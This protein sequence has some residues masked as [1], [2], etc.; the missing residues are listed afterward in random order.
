MQSLYL[1][2]WNVNKTQNCVLK[3]GVIFGIP[4]YSWLIILGDFKMQNNEVHMKRL[5]T[6][7]LAVFTG[8]G[9]EAN[10]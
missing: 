1:T 9:Q 8:S 4:G 6:T 10:N 3:T 2:W 7:V 5:D